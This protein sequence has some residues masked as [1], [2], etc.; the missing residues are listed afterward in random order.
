MV[1]KF[2]SHWRGG[3]RDILPAVQ[4]DTK[5]ERE[6]NKTV[7]TNTVASGTEVLKDQY[8]LSNENSAHHDFTQL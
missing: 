5:K 7:N 4:R 2:R 6:N 8:L 3:I 1:H